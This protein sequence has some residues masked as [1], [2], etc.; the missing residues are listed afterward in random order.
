MLEGFQICN[1]PNV[2]YGF[3]CVSFTRCNYRLQ[4]SVASNSLN[5]AQWK[6]P[7]EKSVRNSISQENQ[8]LSQGE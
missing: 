5:L 7:I 3:R 4:S 8:K 1:N 2:D 6:Y